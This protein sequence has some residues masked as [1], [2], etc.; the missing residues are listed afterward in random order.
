MSTLESHEVVLYDRGSQTGVH[1]PLVVHLPIARG[2]FRASNRKETYFIHM[3]LSE[4]FR[5]VWN[6]YLFS[7]YLDDLSLELNSVKAGCYI[8]EVLL[9]HLV[10]DERFVQAYV[11][12]KVY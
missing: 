10:F 4:P 12:C 1:L 5:G 9:N 6:P 7:V 3:N 11:G 2:T 8:G